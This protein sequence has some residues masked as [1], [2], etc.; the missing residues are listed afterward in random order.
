MS[1]SARDFL[2][3]DY[4]WDDQKVQ[5]MGEL[6]LL[7]Y[8]S[9]LL[10]AD[11]RIT[12]FAGGNTSAKITEIDPLTEQPTEVL[13][14]KG[15]GGDLGTITREGFASL[16]LNILHDLKK[17]YDG[18][19]SEAE[20]VGLYRHAIFNLNPKAPSIDTPM[21]AFIPAK[22]V[23]HTHP[24]SIIAIATAENGPDVAREIWGD[25][26]IWVPWQRPGFGLAL[27]MENALR[28]NPAAE[29]IILGSHGLFT[30]GETAYDC[31]LSTLR[32]IE[33][34]SEYIEE[35]VKQRGRLVFGGARFE[36]LSPD[37]RRG[38]ALE[39]LP[40][41]RGEIGKTERRL[42]SF[43]DNDAVLEFVNSKEARELCEQGTS[44]PDHFLRTKVKPLLLQQNLGKLSLDDLKQALLREMESYRESYRRYYESCKRPDSG[45]MRN[46]NPN[47]FLFSGLGMIASG[48][49]RQTAQVTGEFFVNAINVMRGASTLSAYRGLPPQETFDI[50]YWSLEEAKLRRLPPEKEL[51]RRVAVVTGGAS[52][53]G[54]AIAER[55][56]ASGAAVA[57]ADINAE[58]AE[59]AAAELRDRYGEWQAMAVQADVTREEEVQK[60]IA[61]VVL[62]YG[63][64]DILVSNAG[65]AVSSPLVTTPL[66]DW[67]KQYAV[68]AHGYFLVTREVV[69]V[70]EKQAL[71]GSIIFIVS[72]NALVA[73]K[74]N[75]A[76]SSAK[77]AE[78]HL[79]R[80]LAEELGPQGIRVNS[81]CP[82]AVIRTSIWTPEWRE[83]RAAQY[84]IPADQLEEYYRQRNVLKVNVRP[85]DVAEAALFLASDR[86]SRTTGCI[87]TVDGGIPGAFPR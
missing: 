40:F 58:Q 21:H 3:V 9:N 73:G 85:E 34:A 87:L 23:D 78:L 48:K 29:V 26:V 86:S 82:D 42:Y 50:E 5:G 24:D 19:E 53:I 77:A 30:W 33:K 76:Y 43:V 57:I 66:Q 22:H 44:C 39:L 83:R 35:K 8:R 31:Y 13:W 80:G 61:E 56:A 55:L 67:E 25:K 59:R 54:R 20:M 69:R 16:Y 75:T 10:G 71:G 52:G 45:P 1:S 15:S 81:I 11:L 68:L 18:P 32:A 49:D 36:S 60:A 64:V 74:N 63:G 84:G 14:V 12:N 65:F 79:A 27:S 46:P 70:L 28:E 7:V 51:S 6:D 38:L 17:R 2:H 47:V 72:K 62:R 41:L 4:L 37:R